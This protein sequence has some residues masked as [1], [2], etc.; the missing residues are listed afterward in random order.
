M[1]DEDIDLSDCPEATP[2]MFAS[3]IV[4]KGLPPVRIKTQVTLRIDTDV[5]D[6]FK[7]QGKG[8]KTQINQLLRA[9]MEVQKS[10]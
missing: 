4:R 1:K 6:W 3:A 2:E 8:Y 5:L 10:K 7:S 9:Y